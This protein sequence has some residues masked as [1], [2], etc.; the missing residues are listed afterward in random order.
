[1]SNDGESSELGPCWQVILG[2]SV[3]DRYAQTTYNPC[4]LLGLAEQA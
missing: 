2:P 1:M 4:N 3:L